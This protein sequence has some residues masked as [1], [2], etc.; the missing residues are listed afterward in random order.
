VAVQALIVEDSPTGRSVLKRRLEET[1]F[2]VVGEA[3]TDSIVLVG[4]ASFGKI[5]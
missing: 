5:A 4:S 3:S 2:E 1:G